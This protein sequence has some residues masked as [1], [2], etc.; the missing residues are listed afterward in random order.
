MAEKFIYKCLYPAALNILIP[1]SA[2]SYTIMTVC[3]NF[4]KMF[5]SDLISM[6][7]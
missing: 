3:R 7:Y 1:M 4:S 2:Y 6:S 5:K